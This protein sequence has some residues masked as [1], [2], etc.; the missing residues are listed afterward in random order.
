MDLLSSRINRLPPW[1]RIVAT[2]RN[3]QNVLNQLR[4]LTA[5]ELDAHDEQNLSDVRRFIAG[6]LTAA[7]LQSAV[8]ADG[9]SGEVLTEKL[10]TASSGN[11]LYITMALKAVESGQLDFKTIELLPPG[12]SGM[13]SSIGC[14]P[15]QVWSS[16]RRALCWRLWLMHGSLCSWRKSL[17]R[18]VWTR[19]TDLPPVLD[20]LAP[21]LPAREFRYA[22]FHKSL[23][24]WLTGKDA[25]TGRK[26]AGAYHVSLTKGRTRLADGAGRMQAW[27]HERSP[28]LSPSSPN[29]SR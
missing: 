9:R 13:Y 22:L 14:L 1:L 23:S 6:R 4:G 16:P 2:T 18:Q 25:K 17:V 28:L 10:L 27:H 20:R 24:D 26:E 12:L 11:F 5:R 3:E 15:K 7:T 29:P 21:F 19:T 8:F